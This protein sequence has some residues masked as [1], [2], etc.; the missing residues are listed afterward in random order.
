MVVGFK[1]TQTKSRL[2][3]SGNSFSQLSPVSGFVAVLSLMD[4]TYVIW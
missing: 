2:V 1:R 4:T 3:V